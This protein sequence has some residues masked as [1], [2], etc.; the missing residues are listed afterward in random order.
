MIQVNLLPDVKI[1]FMRTRRNKRLVMMGSLGVVGVVGAVILFLA[2]YVMVAQKK[3]LSD[4]NN[5]IASATSQVSSVTD[6]E[7]ILTV[8]Q[9]LAALPALH[10]QKPVTSR[11][12]TYLNQLTP[13][14][15]TL[16]RVDVNTESNTIGLGGSAPTLELVNTF[17]DTLKFARYDINGQGDLAFSQVVSN[18]GQANGRS[19][20]TISLNYDSKIFDFSSDTVTLSVESLVTTR[21]N[22]QKQVFDSTR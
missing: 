4:I 11:L 12:F 18:I 15:V 20:F 13:A 5:D 21:L 2:S 9:Q 1:E 8:Q 16:S 10:E 22:P 7:R 14:G 19:S 3:H 6:R 17:A